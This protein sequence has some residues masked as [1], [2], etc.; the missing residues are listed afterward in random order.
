MGPAGQQNPRSGKR[1]GDEIYVASEPSATPLKSYAQL[2][3]FSH[4][5]RVSLPWTQG[6]EMLSSP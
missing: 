3:G 2:T 6:N 5:K 1:L 4:R